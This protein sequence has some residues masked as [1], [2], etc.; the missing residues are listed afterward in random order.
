MFRLDHASSMSKSAVFDISDR[1][2]LTSFPYLPSLGFLL[3]I[4]FVFILLGDST[5]ERRY[6]VY[7]GKIR[8]CPS[9]SAI[10]FHRKIF[11]C[12][13]TKYNNLKY[14]KFSIQ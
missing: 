4:G 5:E 1:S 3:S 6:P 11:Q 14:W 12:Q 10:L 2:F 13:I 9:L 7:D 8:K